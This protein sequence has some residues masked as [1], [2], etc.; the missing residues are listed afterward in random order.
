M[1]KSY[2]RGILGVIKRLLTMNSQTLFVLN[3]CDIEKTIH[4]SSKGGKPDLNITEVNVWQ[5]IR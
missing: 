5:T 1:V 4:L 2:F 3:C